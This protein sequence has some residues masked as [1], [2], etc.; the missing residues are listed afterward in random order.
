[1]RHQALR[2]IQALFKRP[3]AAQYALNNFGPFF[4]KT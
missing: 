3:A 4:R 1:V 2:R